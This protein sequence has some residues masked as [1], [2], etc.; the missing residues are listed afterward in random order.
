MEESAARLALRC[1]LAVATREEILDWANRHGDAFEQTGMGWDE[2]H[3]TGLGRLQTR[4]ADQMLS[5]SQDG[6][7][8]DS[9][10]GIRLC[11]EIL[12]AEI[13]RL[14]RKE[15]L[16][17]EFCSSMMTLEAYYLDNT[18][19][20]AYPYF[21]GDLYNACD[22]CSNDDPQYNTDYLLEETQRLLD[23]HSRARS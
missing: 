22:W 11:K 21:L 12:C 17:K 23:E 5:R 3:A 18:P 15:I 7:R 2:I 6:F 19:G 20:R 14:H 16:P 1:R 9:E 8:I 4:L 13:V 10:L